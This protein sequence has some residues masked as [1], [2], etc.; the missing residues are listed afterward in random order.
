[1]RYHANYEPGDEERLGD[2]Q[3]DC[4]NGQYFYFG[5]YYV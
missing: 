2:N 1:L 4:G 3:H 5:D